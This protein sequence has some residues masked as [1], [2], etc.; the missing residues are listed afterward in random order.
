VVFL[1]GDTI[2]LAD[3]NGA[4][5]TDLLTLSLHS[6]APATTALSV[7]HSQVAFVNTSSTDIC[8]ASVSGSGVR[9][10][11]LANFSN[12]SGPAWS[13]DGR[14][15]AFIGPL[16]GGCLDMPFPCPSDFTDAY[17]MDAAS[18]GHTTQS[19]IASSLPNVTSLAW[20]PDGRK[21]AAAAG[22][23]IYTV[24]PKGSDRQLLYYRSDSADITGI[25]WSPDGKSMAISFRHLPCSRVCEMTVAIARLDGSGS[26]LVARTGSAE[27]SIRVSAWSP[28]GSALAYAVDDCSQGRNPCRQDVFVVGAAGGP[29]RKL[30]SNAELLGWSQ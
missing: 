30:L 20:S 7:D 12:L 3:V 9:C 15:L 4:D 21:L 29:S 14:N 24:N 8:I 25:R 2:R 28:D 16:D 6:H 26:R 13:P 19:P 11:G 23:W 22:R 27:G 18:I 5:A 1:R 10:A 17:M